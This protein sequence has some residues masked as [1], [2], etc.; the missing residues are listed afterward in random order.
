MK[1]NPQFMPS[2][3]EAELQDNILPF[4]MN[5]TLDHEKGGFYGAVTNDL[6]VVN[7]VERSAVLC[8]RILWTFS[9]AY[10]AHKNEQYLLVARHAYDYLTRHFWDADYG[11]IY[12]SIDY[13]GHPVNDRKHTYAQSFAIY[14]LTEFYRATGEPE[15]LRL[16][17][18]LFRLI[19]LHTFDVV[20]QGNLECRSCEWQSLDD[21]RL[22]DRDMN[23]AKS[24]N[25]LLHLIEAYT[26]LM[27][28]WDNS[29]L[30]SKQQGLLRAFFDHVVDTQTYHL[31]LF[32]D[33]GWK[34]L[35]NEVS[36]GHDIEASWLLVEAAEV[37]GD[38]ELLALARTLAVKIAQA[39][40]DEG[41]NADGSLS[42][43]RTSNKLNEDRHW[44]VQAEAVVGFYNAY[45]I[46]GQAYFAQAAIHCW[47]YIEDKF[48][49]RQHGDWFKVLNKQNIPY[50]DH[51]KVGPWECPYHHSRVCFEMMQR[52]SD[53]MP[54]V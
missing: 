43:E 51:Y 38:P 10:R 37:L 36:Y 17:Q 44:W 46:S 21:M 30:I 39:V 25:T 14:G 49:D 28:V 45:Q 29:E 18:E 9:T 3:F 1:M 20:N 24:M 11:G 33:L 53:S 50:L 40:Y 7:S 5:H 6:Q 31:K 42:Y 15:S 16:A 26:N 27:M 52:L 19:E 41:R 22:S 12:W 23:C 32:F 4:W 34:S 13:Q 54:I 35:S 2:V 47:Q 8:A 48:V